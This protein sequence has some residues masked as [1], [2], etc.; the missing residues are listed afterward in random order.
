MPRAALLSSLAA[1]IAASGCSFIAVRGPSS[2]DAGRE[3]GGSPCTSSRIAPALDT[4]AAAGGAGLALLAAADMNRSCPPSEE[5]GCLLQLVDEEILVFALVATAVYGA[6]A[7]YGYDR[8]AACRRQQ[9][10]SSRDAH[11]AALDRALAR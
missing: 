8:T 5:M 6:S 3:P 7:W 2:G 1:A 11:P 4:A 10:L 9:S